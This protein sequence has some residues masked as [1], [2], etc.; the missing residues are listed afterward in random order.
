MRFQEIPGQKEIKESLIRTAK[1]GR[2][3]HAQ[4]F[5]GPEGSGKLALAIAYAQYISCTGRLEEDSCGTCPSCVKYAKLVHPD[6]HFVF[7]ATAASST[8]S[9]ETPVEKALE[10]WREMIIENPYFDQYQWYDKIGIENKQGLIGVKESVDIIRK[11]NLKSFESDFKILIM[12]LPE[13]MNATA[14]N[15]LLKMVEEPPPGTVFLLVSEVPGEVL[16]T[17]LSR[18][19][20]IKIPRLEDEDIR[21]S[22]KERVEVSD[23]A[24]EDA[25]NMADGNFN[26]AFSALREEG[27]NRENF[28]QFVSFMRICFAYSMVDLTEWVDEMAKSGREKQKMFL[29]Y[30]LRII[31]ENFLVNTGHSGISHM[32]KY[33]RDWSLKFSKFVNGKNV[34]DIYEELNL[35]YNHI[36]ANANAK[37]VLLDAGLKIGRMLKR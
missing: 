16:P 6:L 24:V 23:E 12:W 8:K 29:S 2:I 1:E 27:F 3:S 9:D 7:P 17:I 18:A 32:T 25:V 22:L 33:E 36:S 10:R 28:D 11:L 19:Q 34:Y 35:A 30:G 26:K 5:Y 4:L 31:R 37:I 21:K 14:A 13:R 20:M 15:K